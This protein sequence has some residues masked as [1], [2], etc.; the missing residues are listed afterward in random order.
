MRVRVL[1][2]H[3]FRFIWANLTLNT[4]RVVGK[5][6]LAKQ[7]FFS[8]GFSEKELSEYFPRLQKESYW[9]FICMVFYFF[10]PMNWV[11][12]F[13]KD[14]TPVLVLHPKED[15]LIWPCESKI[16]SGKYATKPVIVA[17]R[18]HDMMLDT[19]WQDVADKII[20]WL[21]KEGL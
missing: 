14:K 15:Q 2:R 4:L 17:D 7:A 9:A 16:T 10:N 11:S 1:R 5:P 3:F 13:F 6:E 21:E 12:L 19:N 20:N 18:A 8:K